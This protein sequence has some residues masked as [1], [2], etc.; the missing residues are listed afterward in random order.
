MIIWH[1]ISGTLDAVEYMEGTYYGVVDYKEGM[2]RELGNHRW[3]ATGFTHDELMEFIDWCDLICD[4]E[5]YNRITKR[6]EDN[7][8][9]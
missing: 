3:L 7:K 4:K 9:Y 2:E 5:I 1:N 8:W 6:D